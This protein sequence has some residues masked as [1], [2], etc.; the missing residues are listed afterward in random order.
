MKHSTRAHLVN[1]VEAYVVIIN[2]LCDV[3]LV[4]HIKACATNAESLYSCCII[5]M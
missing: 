5:G 1:D 4:L 3:Q 2:D